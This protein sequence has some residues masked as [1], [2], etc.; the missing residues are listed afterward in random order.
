M[1]FLLQR[2]RGERGFVNP[3]LAASLV[4]G[5]FAVSY[6][7]FSILMSP[8]FSRPA[9]WTHK[10]ESKWDVAKGEEKVGE[11]PTLKD[12][13][14][15]RGKKP[16]AEVKPEPKPEPK[17]VTKVAPAP[18]VATSEP[19]VVKP[20][21][22]V[23]TEIT[24]PAKVERVSPTPAAKPTR[25]PSK[26][27]AVRD[28]SQVVKRTPSTGAAVTKPIA[29]KPSPK[30]PKRSTPS[31]AKKVATPAK[32][33]VVAKPKVATPSKQP[34]PAPAPKPAQRPAPEP[35]PVVTAPLS[36][37]VTTRESSFDAEVASPPVNKTLRILGSDHYPR[38]ELPEGYSVRPLGQ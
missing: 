34:A 37:P 31:V 13:E 9:I 5:S 32:P 26:S 6:V 17:P 8:N 33:A 14:R 11:Q 1:R 2:G 22:E 16:T 35:A 21:R 15:R 23:R 3:K 18:K 20:D 4:V 10:G 25:Q 7:A 24:K 28:G 19:E 29:E 36:E 30:V 38:N 27:P 12:S